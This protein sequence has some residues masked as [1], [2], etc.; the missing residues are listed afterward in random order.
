MRGMPN[1]QST[2]TTARRLFGISLSPLGMPS[3]LNS[4]AGS[5]K[6]NVQHGATVAG[7]AEAGKENFPAPITRSVPSGNV[8]L[9]EGH[10]VIR[11][12]CPEH[13]FAGFNLPGT[14]V[15]CRSCGIQ[16]SGEIADLIFSDPNEIKPLA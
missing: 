16:V 4:S 6:A 11:F 10:P 7:T 12:E 5:L 13:G 9:I 15:R 1:R 3:A 14:H 8:R 2:K